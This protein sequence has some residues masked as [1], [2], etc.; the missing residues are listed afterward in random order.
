MSNGS[1]P[2]IGIV[3]SFGGAIEKREIN[4]TELGYIDKVHKGGGIPLMI[5]SRPSPKE[6][7]ER[8]L[9]KMDGIILTG[10]VDI[11][12]AFYADEPSKEL[13]YVDVVRDEF[14]ISLAERCLELEKPLFCICRGMQVL[15]VAMGG[16][17]YQ[18]I[19]REIEDSVQHVQKNR[20]DS[21]I[22][23]VNMDDDSFLFKVY[24][25]KS[26]VNSYHHQGIKNLSD[27]LKAIA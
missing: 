5:P 2:F 25:E 20:D 17:L 6:D 24:G 22:H 7:M 11:H 19:S 23:Y 4:Y 16:T 14:E 12:P 26:F 18:D 3:A 9:S 8:I 21:G 15:N 27:D 1:K 10:G 13:G